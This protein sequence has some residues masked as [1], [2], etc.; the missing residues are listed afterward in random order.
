MEQVIASLKSIY[1][2]VN[3]IDLFVGGVTEKPMS[4]SLIGPTFAYITHKQLENIKISDPFFYD[5]QNGPF[6]KG[7]SD[8]VLMF[9]SLQKYLQ[10]INKSSITADELAEIQKAS[11]SRII[12]DNSDGTITSIQPNAFKVPSG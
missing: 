1:A 12:C 2:S 11:L 4:G 7:Q 9:L 10:F 5:L 8:L 6:T 3:D